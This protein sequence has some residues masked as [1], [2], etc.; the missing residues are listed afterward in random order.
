MP[1]LGPTTARDGAGYMV[2]FMFQPTTYFLPGF[3]L[4]I[5]AALHQ[6]GAGL[7]ARESHAGE[8]QALEA[9]SV[10]LR[11]ASQRVLPE[12]G[13]VDRGAQGAIWPTPARED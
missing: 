11:C 13:G 2:D 7:A 6:G 5:Y 9:S 1:V 4:F 3:T 12:P 8:L 10:D